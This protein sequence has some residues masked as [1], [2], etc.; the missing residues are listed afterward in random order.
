LWPH[1]SAA[2]RARPRP[3]QIASEVPMWL[4]LRRRAMTWHNTHTCVAT[5]VDAPDNSPLTSDSSSNSRS[6]GGSAATRAVWLNWTAGRCAV[7]VAVP[8]LVSM[9]ICQ[10]TSEQRRNQRARNRDC[11]IVIEHASPF[12]APTSP[13]AASAH[14]QA[15]PPASSAASCFT[16]IFSIPS[17]ASQCCRRCR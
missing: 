13:L 8:W 14:P 12:L 2:P 15:M 7:C 16:L 10:G 17:T 3:K 11:S 5:S 4:G 9:T 6:G 1:V